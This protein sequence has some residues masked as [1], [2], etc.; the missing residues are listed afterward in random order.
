MLRS[1]KET[2]TSPRLKGLDD[3]K[4]RVTAKKNRFSLF[5]KKLK[6]DDPVIYDADTLKGRNPMELKKRSACSPASSPLNGRNPVDFDKTNG[7]DKKTSRAARTNPA[8]DPYGNPIGDPKPSTPEEYE[9][10]LAG[11]NPSDFGG[12]DPYGTAPLKSKRSNQK[13]GRDQGKERKAK[14]SDVPCDPY[15]NPIKTNEKTSGLKGR[16]PQDFD[17]PRDP[18][19]NPIDTKI[20]RKRSSLAGRNPQDFDQAKNSSGEPN[21]RRSSLAGRNPVDF[22]KAKDTTGSSKNLNKKTPLPTKPKRSSL[23]G[24]NPQDF[25]KADASTV[26]TGYSTLDSRESDHGDNTAQK[27]MNNK[28]DPG[29]GTGGA[30]SRRRSTFKAPKSNREK[31]SLKTYNT[32]RAGV[33]VIE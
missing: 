22:D 16:N 13:A 10:P 29:N 21:N 23:A 18:Y 20:K 26:S 31:F 6:E 28:S 14:N 3:G 7:Y 12:C 25:D 1:K 8:T 11:R 17:G 2:Q 24:R 19:G 5:G 4:I 32:P 30:K 9:H 27:Q 33:P 15:G